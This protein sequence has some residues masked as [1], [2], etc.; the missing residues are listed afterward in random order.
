MSSHHGPSSKRDRWTQ[1]RRAQSLGCTLGHSQCSFYADVSVL[2]ECEGASGHTL[3]CMSQ[4]SSV[5]QKAPDLSRDQS[6][7]EGKGQTWGTQTPD[8][9]HN[10]GDLP[11]V[12]GPVSCLESGVWVA[13]GGTRQPWVMGQ[14]AHRVSLGL[15][16]P[17][18]LSETPRNQP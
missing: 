4:G 2:P 5:P 17:W 6:P 9:H 10:Q 8:H 3:S 13:I 11:W 7:G 16:T 14:E 1:G 12:P 15:G 18:E